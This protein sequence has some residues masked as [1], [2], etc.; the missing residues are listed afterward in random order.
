MYYL[1]GELDN[2]LYEYLIK[3]KTLGRE[4]RVAIKLQ[5]KES[6]DL[7]LDLLQAIEDKDTFI[8]FDRIECI[9]GESQLAMLKWIVGSMDTLGISK[10]KIIQLNQLTPDEENTMVGQFGKPHK[11]ISFIR[12]KNTNR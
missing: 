12:E 11:F 2:R 4:L 8:T 3:N 5:S 6:Y 7:F 10:N 9:L 1:N